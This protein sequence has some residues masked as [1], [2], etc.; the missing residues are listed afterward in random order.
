MADKAVA[1]PQP[2]LRPSRINA[3]TMEKVMIRGDLSTLTAAERV[4]YYDGVCKSLGL[5]PLTRPFDYLNLN[6]KL[7]LYAKREC[8]EQLRQLRTVNLTIKAREVT[9]GCYVVTAMA[10]LPDGRQ[11][12]SIGAVPIEGLKGESRSNAMMKAE[13]KAKRRVTLSICGLT[14]LD[15]SE[16]DAVRGASPV[17]IDPQTGEVLSS[18]PSKPWSTFRGMLEEFGKLKAQLGPE[19]ESIYYETL[20]MSGVQHANQFRDATTA[21]AAYRT[22]EAALENFPP[23]PPQETK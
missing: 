16:V 21:L 3:E 6:G 8:T 1:L 11:D 4:S 17:A 14:F 18:D 12:E 20:Q 19:G 7:Q 5:N 9:E 2:S 23:A 22:L 13:T 15:E 10:T